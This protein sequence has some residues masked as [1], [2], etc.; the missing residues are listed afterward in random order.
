VLQHG[1]Y[2]SADELT[3]IFIKRCKDGEYQLAESAREKLRTIFERADANKDE[4]FGNTRYVR[5]VFEQTT[6]R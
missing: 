2:H 4:Y 5:N 6:M 1:E 3:T